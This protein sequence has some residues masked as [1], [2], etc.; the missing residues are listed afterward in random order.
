ML[1]EILLANK[2]ANPAPLNLISSLRTFTSLH[3]HTAQ[4]MRPA[5]SSHQY[6]NQIDDTMS[7][8][9]LR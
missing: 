4:V 1:H 8:L 7:G 3:L 9:G 2:Y 5:T 6:R